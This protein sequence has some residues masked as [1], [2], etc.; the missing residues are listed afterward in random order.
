[1]GILLGLARAVVPGQ[2]I[3]FVTQRGRLGDGV[4][5]HDL[6]LVISFVVDMSPLDLAF[7]EQVPERFVLGL[8]PGEHGKEPAL[9][10]MDIGHVFRGG[11]FAVRHVQEV[12]VSDQATEEVPG[13]DMSFVVHDIAAGD[14]KIQRDRAI[15]GNREDEKQLLEV[16]PMVLVEA[17]GD[18]RPRLFA[19]LLF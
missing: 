14:L 2:A 15:P 3:P 17:P 4:L 13:G 19:P 11:Q 16:G 7:G 5:V 18:R 10:L 1:M 6:A 8:G 9:V 12:G